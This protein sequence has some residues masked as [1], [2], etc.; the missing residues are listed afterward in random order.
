[1]IIL[2]VE[3]ASPLVWPS[4]GYL[5]GQ[6]LAATHFELVVNLKVAKALGTTIP[7]SVL[8]RVDHV[9]E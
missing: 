7:P 8:A 6:N 4:C 1:M 9:I 5:E 2:A 3:C